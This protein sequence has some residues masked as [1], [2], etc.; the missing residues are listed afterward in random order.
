MAIGAPKKKFIPW[1]GWEDEILSLYS[2]GASDVEIRSLISKKMEGN[3]YCSNDLWYRWMKE[4]EIL[5]ETVKK[6]HDLCA[7]W[8]ESEGRKN[9]KGKEFNA[10]L[11]YMNMKN[12]FGWADK[13]E[14]K[15]EVKQTVTDLTEEEVDKRIAELQKK[16]EKS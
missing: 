10:T 11:W 3:P 7:V 5:S 8:W 9:L 1:D 14:I 2:E 16:T 4:E 15:A 13:Q 6:G 12:R